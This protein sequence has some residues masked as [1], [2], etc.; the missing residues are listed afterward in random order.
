MISK[1]TSPESIWQKYVAVTENFDPCITSSLWLSWITHLQFLV[2]A[3]GPAE[4][5][6]QGVG[7]V[8]GP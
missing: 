7:P 6:V 4:G 3:S 8:G 2:E 5:R 1:T